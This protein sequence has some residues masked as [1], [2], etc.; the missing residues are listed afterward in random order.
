MAL[1]NS[2]LT[3]K[4]G[5]FHWTSMI[6]LT[7]LY[8]IHLLYKSNPQQQVKNLCCCKPTTY[9][10]Q[11][12]ALH[13]LVKKSNWYRAKAFLTYGINFKHFTQRRFSFV[14]HQF[15][16]FSFSVWVGTQMAKFVMDVGFAMIAYLVSVTVFIFELGLL[17]T[18]VL[19]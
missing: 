7:D 10:L 4:S 16:V 11:I 13:R 15:A 6:C 2:K 5:I 9:I 14:L 3:T 12:I 1:M 18:H 19:L 17:Q 8:T